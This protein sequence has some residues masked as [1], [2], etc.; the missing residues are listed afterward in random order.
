MLIKSRIPHGNMMLGGSVLAGYREASSFLCALSNYSCQHIISNFMTRIP[1]K[2]QT[3]PVFPE[4][5]DISKDPVLSLCL[6][7]HS[8]QQVISTNMTM[9]FIM[10][11]VS[12][13]DMERSSHAPTHSPLP[14]AYHLVDTSYNI[15]SVFYLVLVHGPSSYKNASELNFTLHYSITRGFLG[16]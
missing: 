7:N 8:C 15:H 14:S 3:G 10:P 9:A 4:C 12:W 11:G 16:P 5:Q 2:L 1:H 13:Q 6:S